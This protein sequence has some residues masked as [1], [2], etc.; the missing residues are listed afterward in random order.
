MLPQF[1]SAIK[2][3]SLIIANYLL[4]VLVFS[5][6]CS[7]QFKFQNLRKILLLNKGHIQ[8]KYLSYLFGIR[9]NTAT[10]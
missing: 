1:S 5:L 9:H 2:A 7:G 6:Q 3:R 4:T 10:N 8:M